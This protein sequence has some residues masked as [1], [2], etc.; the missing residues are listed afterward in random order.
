ME[1]VKIRDKAKICGVRHW[2]IAE[3]LGIGE[4]TLTRKLRR[5]LPANEQEKIL[6][7]IHEIA[8]SKREEENSCG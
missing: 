3:A 1:N 6:G 7:L 8:R 2:E 4:A 5:E